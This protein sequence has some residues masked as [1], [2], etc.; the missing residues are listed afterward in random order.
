M[1]HL[2]DI[3]YGTLDQTVLNKTLQ[4]LDILYKNGDTKRYVWTI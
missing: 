1:G 2:D 3:S 4:H